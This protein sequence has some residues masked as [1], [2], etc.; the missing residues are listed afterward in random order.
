MLDKPIDEIVVGEGGKVVGVRSGGEIAKCKQV[1]CDPSYVPD[2]VRKRGKV[3]RCICLMDHPIPN[4]KDALS[5]QIIIPQK[6]VGRHSDI[7]VS[8]VSYTHQVAAKGWFIAMVSTTV[9]TENPEVQIKPGIDLL[10]PIRQK[11]VSVSDYYEPIDEGLES[12][13]FISQS[14]DATTHFETTCT[15]VLNIYKRATGE[16]FDFSIIKNQLGDEE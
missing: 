11:F 16:D 9:E 14:Y 12:Q 4:T 5:T 15:D 3:I 10:G 2:K 6:Q 13:I 7:Y 1:F 8:M